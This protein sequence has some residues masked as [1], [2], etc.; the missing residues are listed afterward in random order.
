MMDLF[1]IMGGLFLKAIPLEVIKGHEE[2]AL[3]NHYQS[4]KRLARRGGLNPVEAMA[5]IDD[6]TLLGEGGISYHLSNLTEAINL[7]EEMRLMRLV[8]NAGET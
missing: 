1:P 6:K 2:Q 8:T 3:H 5:V 4:L 7:S